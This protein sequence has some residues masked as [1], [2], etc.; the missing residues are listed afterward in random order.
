MASDLPSAPDGWGAVSDRV[1]RAVAAAHPGATAAQRAEE[2]QQRFAR[3]L[4][5]GS[6]GIRLVVAV[7]A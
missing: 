1:S 2:Q 5:M 6:L 7:R 3:L 4:S